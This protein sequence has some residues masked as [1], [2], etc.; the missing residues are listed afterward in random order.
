MMKKLLFSKSLAH[1]QY[2]YKVAMPQKFIRLESCIPVRIICDTSQSIVP[3]QERCQQSEETASLHD[4]QVG[5][6][7]GGALQVGD[8]EEEEGH[9]KGEEEREEG[10]GRAEGAEDEEGCEDK[11]AL[12]KGKEGFSYGFK[13]KGRLW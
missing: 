7:L 13:G 10:D 3:S 9:I 12:V 8:A 6:A 11:P 2:S 4:V 5:R 1:D